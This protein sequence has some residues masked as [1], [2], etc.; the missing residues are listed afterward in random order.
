MIEIFKQMSQ[1]MQV[2]EETRYRRFEKKTQKEFE[3]AM[4]EI[5]DLKSLKKVKS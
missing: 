5:I 3:K 1:Y 2:D 4:D